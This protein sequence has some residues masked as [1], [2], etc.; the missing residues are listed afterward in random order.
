MRSSEY[1]P[2]RI[3]L[4]FSG[5]RRKWHTYVICHSRGPEGND[6]FAVG[7]QVLDDRSGGDQIDRTQKFSEALV[8]IDDV[9]ELLDLARQVSVPLVRRGWRGKYG[10]WYWLR[11]SGPG[12]E[13]SIHWCSDAEPELKPV[14]QRRD[15]ILPTVNRLL[16]GSAKENSV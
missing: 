10:S 6:E 2:Q 12:C 7:K 1:L 8:K 5:F 14:Y 11:V 16:G 4:R 15:E 3:T 13:T 9:R